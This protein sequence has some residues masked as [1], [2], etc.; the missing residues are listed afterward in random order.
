[1]LLIRSLITLSVVIFGVV[2][3]TPDLPPCVLSCATSAATSAGCG[4]FTNVTCVCNSPQFVSAALPCLAAN[5]STQDQQTAAQVEALL[6]GSSSTSLS[7]ETGTSTALPPS[8]PTTHSTSL[9]TGT[10]TQIVTSVSVVTSTPSS[11]VALSGSATVPTS[12]SSSETAIPTTSTGAATPFEV[13]F[14]VVAFP[15]II[16]ALVAF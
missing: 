4:T 16:A 13:S 2:A 11:S 14:G 9:G 15:A 1:M 7:L 6:C 5:C 3:Q 8:S 12:L 10:V